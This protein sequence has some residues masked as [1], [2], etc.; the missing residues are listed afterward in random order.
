MNGK[1]CMGLPYL[2]KWNLKPPNKYFQSNN[3]ITFP[4]VFHI[5]NAPSLSLKLVTDLQLHQE[6]HPWLSQIAH[7]DWIRVI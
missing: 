7:H 4:K 2:M 3:A 1:I 6:F 5:I